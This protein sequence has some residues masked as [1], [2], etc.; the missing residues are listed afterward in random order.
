MNENVAYPIW[1]KKNFIISLVVWFEKT[2]EE[3][4]RLSEIIK[5]NSK[6]I[7]N[8]KIFVINKKNRESIKYFSHNWTCTNTMYGIIRQTLITMY[9]LSLS[10]LTNCC[11]SWFYGSFYH[12]LYFFQRNYGQKT[13]TG[14][15][16]ENSQNI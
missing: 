3:V 10:P 14:E 16:V 12:K 8:P 1:K 11:W 7:S 5:I 15:R 2:I 6:T 13:L 9:I 4:C